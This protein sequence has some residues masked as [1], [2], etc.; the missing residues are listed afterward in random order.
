M[1]LT[2]TGGCNA[3]ACIHSLYL[4]QIDRLSPGHSQMLVGQQLCMHAVSGKDG[5]SVV[6]CC[7]FSV[8]YSSLACTPTILF[9]YCYCYVTHRT[10]WCKKEIQVREEILD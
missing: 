4:F 6:V 9:C 3:H 7:L 8:V 10:T 1:P 5:I 2:V